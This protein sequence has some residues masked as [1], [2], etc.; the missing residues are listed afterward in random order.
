MFDIALHRVAGVAVLRLQGELV[1]G[2]PVDSLIVTGRE[3]MASNQARVVLDL[4]HVTRI[5][6]SG[7]GTLLA[8][9][10]DL[11]SAEGGLVLLSPSDRLR[12]LLTTARFSSVFEIADTET[13]AVRL[14]TD[15][16]KTPFSRDKRDG[17][18]DD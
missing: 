12:S 9:R 6:S 18:A 10:M 4:A 8:M 13:A 3:L 1:F 17:D 14:L 7:L 5:D 16:R 15:G 2:R 11:E